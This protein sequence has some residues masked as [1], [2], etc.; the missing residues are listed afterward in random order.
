ML[1]LVA[2]LLKKVNLQ[3]NLQRPVMSPV[4]CTVGRLRD[5]VERRHYKDLIST[6]D[7]NASGVSLG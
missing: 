7:V 2:R 6:K 1:Y 3:W 4:T 5:I